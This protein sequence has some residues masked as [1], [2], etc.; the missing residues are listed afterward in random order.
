MNFYNLNPNEVIYYKN[1]CQILNDRSKNKGLFSKTSHEVLITNENFVFV[2]INKK[3]LFNMQIEMESIQK[4]QIIIENGIPKIIQKDNIVE[5]YFNNG[6]KIISLPT[7]SE[8]LKF[9]NLAID[10]ATGKPIDT[11]EVYDEN[12]D[13]IEKVVTLGSFSFGKPDTVTENSAKKSIKLGDFITISSEVI[14]DSNIE[15]ET[16]NK[17]MT[18][19]TTIENQNGQLAQLKSLL[20]DGII[21]KEE[22]ES[23]KR[24][25]QGR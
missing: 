16:I 8:A 18:Q 2:S 19:N 24:E 9:I 10:L 14:V 4:E 17:D 13:I 1:D 25:I 12:S 7:S 5:M 22:F 23:K 20:N 6:E 11:N 15:K 3:M 21:S